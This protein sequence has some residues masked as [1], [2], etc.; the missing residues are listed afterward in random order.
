M[1]HEL[2]ILP[3]LA[4]EYLVGAALVKGE[5]EP[6]RQLAHVKQDDFRSKAL[7]ALWGAMQAVATL[8]KRFEILDV[9]EQLELARNLALLPPPFQRYLGLLMDGHYNGDNINRYANHML[10]GTLAD[11]AK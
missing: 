11:D 1:K 8:R 6:I 4:E 2:E 3:G 7:G 5:T 9:I 10:K